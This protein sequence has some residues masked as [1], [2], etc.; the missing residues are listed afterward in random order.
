MSLDLVLGGLGAVMLLMDK[1]VRKNE[2]ANLLNLVNIH[3]SPI[4]G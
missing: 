2:T 4:N 3:K 1:I